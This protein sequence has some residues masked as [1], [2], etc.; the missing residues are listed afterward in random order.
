MVKIEDITK[1]LDHFSDEL[2]NIIARILV[3][4]S[5]CTAVDNTIYGDY[6]RGVI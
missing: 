4:Q 2:H 5:E 6:T 1:Q 3:D